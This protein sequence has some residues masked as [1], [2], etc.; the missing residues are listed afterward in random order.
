MK[1]WLF[2]GSFVIA[3]LSLGACSGKDPGVAAGGVPGGGAGGV[4]SLGGTTAGTGGTPGGIGPSGDPVLTV[5]GGGGDV[6]GPGT[7]IVQM[8]STDYIK[9]LTADAKLD[10][11][12]LD[13]LRAGGTGCS[14]KVLYPY[15]NTVFPGGL[16]SPPIMW[17]GAAD[18]AYVR[19]RF[20]SQNNLDFQF[21]SGA[22]N[23]GELRIPQAHWTEI[24]RRTQGRPLLVTLSTKSGSAVSTCQLTLRIAQGTMNGALYYNTYNHPQAGG[25]G[26]I[27][28][29]TL[30][31]SAPELYLN[32]LGVPPAGPCISCH[33][34]SANG[35]VLATSLHNYTPGL[36]VL[37]GLLGGE[38][39]Q[40][41]TVPVTAAVQP[42]ARTRVGDATFGAL[43]P[44]GSLLLQMGNPQCTAGA[45]TFPRAPNNFFL[46]QGPEVASLIDTR[47]GQPVQATGLEANNYMW[48]PQFSPDGKRVVFNHAKP[49]GMGGTDRR[50]LAMM[51]FDQATRRFSNLRVIASR[52]GVAP[53]LAYAPE[54]SNGFGFPLTV[55]AGGCTQMLQGNDGLGHIA[56]GSCTGPCYPAWPFFT[57]DGRGVV[58]AL[59]SE[60]DF[61]VAFPGRDTA[62]KSELWYVNLDDPQRP[63]Q[64]RMDAANTGMMG[65]DTLNNYYPT[66]LPVQVGGYYWVF[67]TTMRKWGHRK[68]EAAPG[69]F[70]D[71]FLSGEAAV[72]AVK[73]RIWVSAIRASGTASELSGGIDKDPSFPGF[74]LEGQSDTGNTRAFAALNPCRATG[75][76]C[77]SGLDC[78]TGFCDVK[79]GADK[80]M[81][82]TEVMCSKTN[83]RCKTDKDCCPPA[84]GEPANSCLG[85]YCG[86]VVL[87]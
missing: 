26:A 57:P 35:S 68:I 70:V 29:L 3:L 80:G 13:A 19:L 22:S 74:Y 42:T 60:P 66:V 62:S 46:V 9:D 4:G 20:E 11:G 54:A 36:D 58:Y 14:A 41:F 38:P 52:Q 16:I 79:P 78:C 32:D 23:P 50:E 8:T 71:Q 12:T 87:N 45:S 17:E 59:I 85:G 5:A 76:E 10:K 24:A 84:M 49:D 37:G 51:D 77:Q 72:Q 7:G 31:A 18:A 43:T 33:S 2:Y 1:P 30:G 86:F 21:A 83:E 48:M 63:R 82:V 53:S 81:C 15:N 44:D 34:V 6:G 61:A 40:S 69:A 64:F 67:W 27:L 65:E 56:N 73:K 28:R 25:V 39:F 55:G 75:K 47:T